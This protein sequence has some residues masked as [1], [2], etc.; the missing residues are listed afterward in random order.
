MATFDEVKLRFEGTAKDDLYLAMLDAVDEVTDFGLI[1]IEK[2][3]VCCDT[4]GVTKKQ[5]EQ[6]KR[7][8]TA[9][10]KAKRV[11]AMQSSN[12][13]YEQNAGCTFRIAEQDGTEQRVMLANFAALINADILED[14]GE[15]T[16][17]K[18]EISGELYTG[19]NLPTITIE[20]GAFE[21]LQWVNAEWGGR[22]AISPEDKSKDYLRYAIQMLSR[23]SIEQR[24]TYTHSGFRVIDGKR[25]FLYHGGAI[26][27]DYIEAK[28]PDR[29]SML[30]FPKDEKVSARDAMIE[31]IKLLDVAKPEVSYPLFAATYLAPL[32]EILNPTF[33]PWVEG[34]SGA[35]KTSYSAVFQNHFAPKASEST[36]LADWMGTAGSLEKLAFHA[37]DVFLIV[38]DFRPS[39]DA[40]ERLEMNSKADR[41][42]RAVGNRHGRSRLTA[43]SELKKTYAPRGVVLATAERGTSGKS[44]QSRVMKIAIEPGA[45]DSAKLSE[46]QRK[47]NLYGYAMRSF[48]EMIIEN[49]DQLSTE[50]PEQVRVIRDDQSV[51]GR[52]MRLPTAQAVLYTAFSCAM[53]HAIDVGAITDEQADYHEEKCLE[54]LK[55][56]SESQSDD[57]ENESPTEVFMRSLV[58]QLHAGLLKVPKKGVSTEGY[59]APNGLRVGWHDEESIYL[60]PMAYTSVVEQVRK[61]GGSFAADEKTLRAEFGRDGWIEPDKNGKLTRQTRDPSD[62]GSKVYATVLKRT[63]FTEWVIDTGMHLPLY[64]LPTDPKDAAVQVGDAQDAAV[65]D[66]KK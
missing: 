51:A 27:A 10:K 52:H 33:V 54:V 5:V 50:L 17:R 44:T 6:W 25:V 9:A 46:A 65:Q 39:S 26:G 60:L 7:L 11:D 8:V 30:E 40:R 66:A 43:T 49:W 63:K 48:I 32:T 4:V 47:R 20:A 23:D 3:G 42:I 37:K 58:S 14:D 34:G 31:S 56:L 53:S 38:D 15:G 61:S 22:V 59:G 41:I 35:F 57:V 18:I 62:K 28:L 55:Q 24:T 45:V 1:E 21:K 19:E 13:S 64:Q 2:L 36:M 29:L 16:S 12:D